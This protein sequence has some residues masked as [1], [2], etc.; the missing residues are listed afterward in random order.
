MKCFLL[1][2]CVFLCSFL[3]TGSGARAEMGEARPTRGSVRD[4]RVSGVPA[5][6]SRYR[7]PARNRGPVVAGPPSPRPRRRR[8]PGEERMLGD[9]PYNPYKASNYYPYYNYYYHHRARPRQWQAYGSGYRQHGLPD[10][11]PDAAHIQAG[12]YVHRVAMYNLRCAAEENCLASNSIQ[13]KALEAKFSSVSDDFN[14]TPHLCTS[15]DPVPI[16]FFPPPSQVSRR[17]KS[18]RGQSNAF[19]EFVAAAAEFGQVR[20]R[21][22]GQ[23]SAEVP[24][25]CEEP[26]ERGLPAQQSAARLGVAQLSQSLSQHGRLQSVRAVGR[27]GPGAGGGGPQGQ[28]LPGG[29]FLRR[30]ILPAIR[31]HLAHSGFESRLLRHIQRRYRL[32]VD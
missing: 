11:V 22:P 20:R 19:H 14:P 27:R 6:G 8:G 10:L 7:P 21:L 3:P 32:S 2:A 15:R 17:G 16:S 24:A 9:D 1:G 12:S 31:L 26:G 13:M 18:S 25:A 4:G 30:R 28:L 29:H 5:R 23:G